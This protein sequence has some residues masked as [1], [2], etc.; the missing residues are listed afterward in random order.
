MKGKGVNTYFEKEADKGMEIGERKER[1]REE[2][3]RVRE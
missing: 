3:K 2:S 1:K